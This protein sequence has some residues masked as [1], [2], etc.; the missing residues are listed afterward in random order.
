MTFP[1]S[2]Q[3]SF[4][5]I[6]KFSTHMYYKMKEFTVTGLHVVYYLVTESVCQ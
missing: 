6:Q 4:S 5:H 1:F 2:P 3:F